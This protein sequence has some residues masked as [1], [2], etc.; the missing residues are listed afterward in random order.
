MFFLLFGISYRNNIE[1]DRGRDKLHFF[2]APRF[3]VVDLFFEFL[4]IKSP[5]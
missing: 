1:L 4:F 3:K 5:R 2:V